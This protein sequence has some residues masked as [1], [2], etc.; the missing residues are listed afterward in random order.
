MIEPVKPTAAASKKA[1]AATKPE[2][3]NSNVASDKAKPAAKSSKAGGEQANPKA[4]PKA[5]KQTPVGWLRKRNLD[6]LGD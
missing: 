4:K 6:Q 1:K 3:K 2:T 5:G